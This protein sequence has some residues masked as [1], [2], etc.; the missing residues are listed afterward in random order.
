MSSFRRLLLTA[1]CLFLLLMVSSPLRAQNSLVAPDSLGAQASFRA[2]D[3]LRAPDSL[4]IQDSLQARTFSGAQGSFQLVDG[5]RPE[6]FT[7]ARK[8]ISVG[9]VAVLSLGILADSYYT[10]WKDA[11]KSFSFYT[12]PWF[13][14]PHLGIDRFGHL[15]GAYATFK[16]GRNVLLWGGHDPGAALWW[17]AG[18]A[19]WHS[20]EIEIGDGFSEYGF[21]YKDLLMGFTGVGYG[22]LQTQVPFFNNFN[23]KFSYWS[24]LGSKTP[25]S[26]VSDYDAMTI[27]L[28]A[29]VHN[30]LP[31]S[32]NQYW[33]EFIQLAVGYG[34]ADNQTLREL[35]IGFDFNL[36]AFTPCNNDMLL[37]QRSV[38]TIHL[39][40]PAVSFTQGKDPA[41]YGLYF[42]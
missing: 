30:L 35:V 32:I 31:A 34:T 15:M 16:I 11:E 6:Q 18:I 28:T 27:W 8:T 19:A 41:W 24:N 5:Y 10:W 20:L 14:P 29:N 4:R 3:S 1:H 2:Q 36:E 39:P 17:A 21:D 9:L 25:A 42:K 40:A 13:G 37:I 26:F 7:P 22:I 12:E 38:N 33:P 23:F